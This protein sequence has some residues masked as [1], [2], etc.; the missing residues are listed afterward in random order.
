MSLI[1]TVSYSQMQL[2][3]YVDDVDAV[4]YLTLNFCVD[5]EGKI[6]S[7]SIIP[8]KTNYKNQE[9]I[10]KIVDAHKGVEFCTD[11]KNDCY[12]YTFPVVNLKYK[13]K[14]LSESECKKCDVYKKGKYKYDS[15]L[16][17][18]TTI[19][20]RGNVQIEKDSKLKLRLKLGIEWNSPCEYTMTYLKVNRKEYKY[21]LGE[22]TDVKIIEILENGDYVYQFASLGQKSTGVIKKL[23]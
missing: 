16:F 5:D 7:T 8:E 6:N 4:K 22:Q 11:C 21:L 14:E 1:S 15:F 23:N 18:N 17:A 20:R 12:D 3:F 13:N 9:N 2:A 19:K 10:K